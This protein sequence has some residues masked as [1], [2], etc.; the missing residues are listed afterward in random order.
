MTTLTKKEQRTLQFE[1]NRLFSD[2]SIFIPTSIDDFRS[3]PSNQSLSRTLNLTNNRIVFLTESGYKH[4]RAI[5]DVMHRSSYFKGMAEY[6][7]IWAAWRSVV[8]KW[9]SN[10]VTPKHADEVIQAIVDLV[11]QEIDEYSFV[12]PLFGI[13][14]ESIDS[15]SLGAMT[16]LRRPADIFSSAGIAHNHV[17]IPLLIDIYEECLWLKGSTH[18]TP[19]VAQQKF[20]EQAS[21]TAGML[22]IMAASIYERGASNFRIGTVMTP[23][24]AN[25]R[26]IWFS[27]AEKKR[28]LVTHQKF[29]KG[30]PFPINRAFEHEPDITQRVIRGLSI[31][32]ASN[33]SELDEAIA[34][35][36]YWYSDAQRDPTIVMKLVKYWSCVE[37]FFSFENEEITHAVSAG[38]ASI[39]VFGGFRF[40]PPSEYNTLKKKISNLYSLRSRAVH[41]GSH[42]HITEQDVAQFSQWVAWMI[43]SMIALVELGYTNLKEVKAQI[44]RL[45]GLEERR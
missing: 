27:W 32:Q 29:P 11:G 33:K 14:L 1:T 19:Q 41:R 18:G 38:L 26:S 35:A 25:G 8:E 36:V 12:V 23:E 45:D 40:V 31:L 10:G 44:D 22:A 20:S 34:R 15:F 9:L 43:V 7:D 42:Q 6:S 13:E 4:F 39:L 37:A 5:V 16:V 24:T 3:I 28:S 17:D 30:Q 21:L 2:K